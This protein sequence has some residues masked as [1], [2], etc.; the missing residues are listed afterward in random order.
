MQTDYFDKMQQVISFDR[1]GTVLASSDTIALV[2][3]GIS[4]YEEVPF[5][6]SFVDAVGAMQ[7]GEEEMVLPCIDCNFFG[8]E[9]LYDFVFCPPEASG[10]SQ[11]LVVLDFS[12][13]YRHVR[14]YQQ[15]HN[16]SILAQQRLNAELNTF[17]YRASHD[18][19]SPITKL[20]GL[21]RVAEAHPEAFSMA[22]LV[23]LLKSGAESL[24]KLNRS[25]CE[26]GELR[27]RSVTAQPIDL[28]GW[29]AAQLPEWQPDQVSRIAAGI[30]PA[31]QVRTDA[32]L[33]GIA[34]RELI[35]N[36]LL[37]STG[38]VVVAAEL[39]EEALQITVTD[40]G[41]GIDPN[42]KKGVFRMFVR[43]NNAADRF[44]LGLYKAAVVAEK[45]GGTIRHFPAPGQ[46]TTMRLKLPVQRVRQS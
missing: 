11:D 33:L 25:M 19:R 24:E 45:L 13:Q 9:G 31:L 27:L 7:P 34:L 36:A 2:A 20:L 32:W 39:G 10:N 17:F 6:L 8:E 14:K 4:L 15:G 43:G 42:L 28:G 21:I 5:L 26:V 35:D 23:E 30:A 16:E 46:G 1:H 22:S 3:P 44:G 12:K 41:I 38:E 37:E 29:L 40:S 18:L